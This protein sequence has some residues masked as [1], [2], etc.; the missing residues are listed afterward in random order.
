MRKVL[1]ILL[2][3]VVFSAV[4]TAPG[5]GRLYPSGVN[6]TLKTGSDLYQ[7]LSDHPKYQKQIDKQPISVQNMAE[8]MIGPISSSEEKSVHKQVSISTGFIDLVNH[9][10]HA[11]AI[12]RIQ[13]GYFDRYLANLMRQ[14]DDGGK[15][16]PPNMV[17]PRYWADDIMND[18][19]S[20]FNQ[21]IGMLVAINISHHYLGHFTRYE[22]ILDAGKLTPINGLL[23]PD[24]WK[25]SLKAGAI[26]S[27]DCACTSE[28]IQGLLEGIQKLPHRPPWTLLIVPERADLRQLNKELVHFQELYYKGLLK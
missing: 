24:E 5:P 12:D 15:I 9:L 26:N 18:Q 10:A 27:F 17:D 20:Y 25:A 14:S 19:I 8:P 11:K 2:S 4:A 22:K 16:Q 21:I 3:L 23:S 7:T 1:G 28:G 6:E 13:P